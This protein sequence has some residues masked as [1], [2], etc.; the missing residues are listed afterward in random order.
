MVRD[1]EYWRARTRATVLWLGDCW[2][3]LVE[4]RRVCRARYKST[5][6]R[7]EKARGHGGPHVSGSRSWGSDESDMRLGERVTVP[8]E[9]RKWRR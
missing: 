1:L 6:R 7:C 4:R 9:W 2:R 3:S 8:P 5:F